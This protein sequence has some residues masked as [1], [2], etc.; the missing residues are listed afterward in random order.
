MGVYFN[1][2]WEDEQVRDL[3]QGRLCIFFFLFLRTSLTITTDYAWS[4][5]QC[6]DAPPVEKGGGAGFQR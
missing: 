2:S 3:L 6:T 1:G 5:W 4:M